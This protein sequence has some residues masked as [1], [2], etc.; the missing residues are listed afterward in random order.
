[1]FAKHTRLATAARQNV[2]ASR[3]DS[4]FEGNHSNGE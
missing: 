1:M 2:Y 3:H 4:G